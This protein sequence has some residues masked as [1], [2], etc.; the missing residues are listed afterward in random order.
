MRVLEVLHWEPTFAYN[1]AAWYAAKGHRVERALLFAGQAAPSPDSFDALV[2]YGG[3]MSAYDEAGHP[4]IREEL[5]FMEETMKA[6][7]PLL[8]ICL[9][10]QLLARLLGARVARSDIP[11]FGFVPQRLT[12]AGAA[13]PVFSRL[14]EPDCPEG[15]DFLSMEWHGDA[16]ELPS[17]ARLLASG[18][19]WP[20]QAFR[21]GDRTYATQFHLEFTREHMA[22]AMEHKAGEVPRGPGLESP[23]AFLAD[24]GRFERVRSRMELLLEGFL[25]LAAPGA[26]A[27]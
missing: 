13:D 2:V 5:R 19:R 7:K 16:W 10:S 6:G 17:G 4:W 25:G 21:Y 14:P 9:G 11:E 15:G 26:G 12:A 8:G 3:Y 27:A 1:N 18:E 24:P 20:N 22:W 23:E